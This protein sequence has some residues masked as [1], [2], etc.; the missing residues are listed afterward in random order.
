M[1]SATGTSVI[2]CRNPFR[3]FDGMSKRAVTSTPKK[4]TPIVDEILNDHP[5]GLVDVRAAESV[6]P[7]ADEAA[8]I[9][10]QP[11]H[12]RATAPR[13]RKRSQAHSTPTH[14]RPPPAWADEIIL[15]TAQLLQRVPLRWQTIWRMV[16]ENRFPAPIRLTSSRLGWRWSHILR[17]LS[18]REARPVERRP[19][20]GNDNDNTKSA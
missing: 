15:T 8:A 9:S 17:W 4:R 13:K 2:G 3:T 1:C 10:K 6:P 5:F 11:A 19:Y 14:E 16:R 7:P 20:F 12:G 18:E